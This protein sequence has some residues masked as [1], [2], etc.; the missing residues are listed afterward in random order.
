MQEKKKKVLDLF[1]QA[2]P[3]MSDPEV[4]KLLAFGQGV[5]FAVGRDNQNHDGKEK[6]EQCQHSRHD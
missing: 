5:A 2:L 6:S 3:D 1:K 4:D